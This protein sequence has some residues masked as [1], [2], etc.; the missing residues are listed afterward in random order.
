MKKLI[1]YSEQDVTNLCGLLNGIVVSG[2]QNC[3]NIAV[4]AQILDSGMPV[5]FK[6]TEQLD[7]KEGEESGISTVLPDNRLAGAAFTENR[8]KQ[9]KS[10]TCRERD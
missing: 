7:K 6:E 5:E 9:K 10:S 2:I 8:I 4:I 1:T 3:K